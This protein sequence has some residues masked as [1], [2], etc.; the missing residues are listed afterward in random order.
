M[1]IDYL[2]K[3]FQSFN[4][5][6]SDFSRLRYPLW[7]ERSEADVGVMVMEV[8]SAV[9]DE[10]SY[11][12]DRVAAEATIETATQRVSLVRQARLVDYEPSPAIAAITQL[13]VDVAGGVTSI[14]SS[15]RCSALGPDGEH[16]TFE[17]GERLA[18]PDTG[19][20]VAVDYPVDPRWNTGLL[21]Y[22]WDSSRQCL[23][24]GSTRFWV[25]GTGIGF[26]VDQ[27]LLIDTAGPTSADPPVR[28][29]SS[30]SAPSRRP[31]TPSSLSP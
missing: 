18:D 10:L 29:S 26:T 2:A 13:Q 4:Q 6:L 12:Q 31:R 14:A 3:D 16:V 5:A 21:P 22:W 15:L 20:P 19:A 27:T 11:L 24:G 25:I 28:A 23:P 30:R 1:L 9:A 17:V 8:L 7:V